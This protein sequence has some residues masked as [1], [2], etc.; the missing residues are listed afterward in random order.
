M[1]VY[2]DRD[3]TTEVMAKHIFDYIKDALRQERTFS[4]STSGA[5]YRIGPAVKLE[6][7]RVWETS[8]TWAEYSEA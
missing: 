8:G 2:K 3:P 4:A 5:S 1:I 6:T 7:W